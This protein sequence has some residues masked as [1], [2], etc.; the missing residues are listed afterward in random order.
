[1]AQAKSF[2]ST[3]FPSEVLKI[4][5]EEARPIEEALPWLGLAADEPKLSADDE[6][7]CRLVELGI[8][9]TFFILF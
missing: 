8:I 6:R 4:P 7:L 5:I 2:D 9:E 1:M 3:G